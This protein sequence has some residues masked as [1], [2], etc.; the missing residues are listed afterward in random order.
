MHFALSGDFDMDEIYSHLTTFDGNGGRTSAYMSRA[1][2]TADVSSSLGPGPAPE[3]PS[4]TA[5]VPSIHQRTFFFVFKYYAVV[6]KCHTSAPWERFDRRPNHRRSSNHI[7]IA[8]CN[9]ILALSLSGDIMRTVVRRQRRGKSK[10]EGCLLD[11]FG[12]WTLLNI[13]SFPDEDHTDRGESTGQ[14]LVNGP[15]A[16]LDA[17]LVEYRDAV[18]RNNKLHEEIASLVTPPVRFLSKH[19]CWCVSTD[20]FSA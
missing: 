14:E 20:F 2:I 13:Q 18:T 11:T 5:I 12:P 3:P 6:A 9:S 4:P 17:L 7:D 1:Y 19:R 15:Y 16:F 8:E 10:Q